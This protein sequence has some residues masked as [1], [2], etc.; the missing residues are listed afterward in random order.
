MSNY[1]QI[2]SQQELEQLIGRY[3]DGLTTVDEEK[4]LRW[5]L[6]HC[7][8]TSEAI[9]DAQLV[10]GYFAAHTQQRHRRQLRATRQR[11]IGIAASIAIVL[12][13]G[14]YAL[15]HKQ[16]PVDVCIAYVNGQVVQGD[17]QVM[18]MVADDLDRIDNAAN[19]MTD[20]LSSLGEALELDNE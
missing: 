14:S 13:V 10:M 1:R 7:R 17:D 12:A 11:I 19:A 20:Q 6:A 18:A 9:D 5:N 4:D 8:W 3:F 2:N 15:W 16:R